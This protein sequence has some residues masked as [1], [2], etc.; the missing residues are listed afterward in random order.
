[1]ALAGGI[2]LVGGILWKKD[3]YIVREGSWKS[4]DKK[5]GVIRNRYSVLSFRMFGRL[6]TLIVGKYGV[7]RVEKTG[8]VKSTNG[9]FIR[10]LEDYKK[11]TI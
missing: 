11:D 3:P 8:I 9:G 4:K 10:G 1:M 7:A 5:R 2:V 6:M